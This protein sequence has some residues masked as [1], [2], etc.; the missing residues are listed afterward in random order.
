MKRDVTIEP[1]S[2][3]NW[4]TFGGDPVADTHSG[5]LSA[6]ITIAE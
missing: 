3:K 2:R 5:S 4:L 6:S 1:T